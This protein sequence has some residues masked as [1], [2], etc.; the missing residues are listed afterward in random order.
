MTRASKSPTSNR[1]LHS[2]LADGRRFVALG[3]DRQVVGEPAKVPSTHLGRQ[4][5]QLQRAAVVLGPRHQRPPQLARQ[6]EAHL[7]LL[8]GRERALEFASAKCIRGVR[9]QRRTQKNH[10]LS[11]QRATTL[12]A[13]RHQLERANAQIRGRIRV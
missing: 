1:L 12:I 5:S 11:D 2:D 6:R 10:R 7:G 9:S 3:G 8:I 4:P 13:T